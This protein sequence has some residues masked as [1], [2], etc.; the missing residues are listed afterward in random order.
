MRSHKSEPVQ[1][2]E[3]H[4]EKSDF[5]SHSAPHLRSSFRPYRRSFISISTDHQT[6]PNGIHHRHYLTNSADRR[7]RNESEALSREEVHA[8][9]IQAWTA[10]SSSALFQSMPLSRTAIIE[11]L[12]SRPRA[13]SPQLLH[14]DPY[15]R[16]PEVVFL[17][18]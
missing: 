8:A 18:V 6:S 1:R 4:G 7:K 15:S 16:C 11:S 5:L 9:L 2:Y 13:E 10:G 17:S 12:R 14:S 3:E